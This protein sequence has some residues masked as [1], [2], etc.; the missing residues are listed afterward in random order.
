MLDDRSFPQFYQRLSLLGAIFLVMLLFLLNRLW[1][2]QVRQTDDFT[3]TIARQCVR[4]IRLEPVRGRLFA[5]DGSVL[6][7]NRARYDLVFHPADM[8]QPGGYANTVRFILA[9]AEQLATLLNRPMPLTA[10][11]LE[12]H[13]RL[14]PA[15]DLL[16]FEDLTTTDIAIIEET[17][18]S[19][20]G[21]EIVPTIVRTYPQPGVA[22][23]LLGFSGRRIPE[24]AATAAPRIHYARPELHG[25]DGL[26]KFYEQELAGRGGEKLVRVNTAGYIHDDI[27]VTEPP[28]DGNDL[29]LTLDPKAQRAAQAALAG[30]TGAIVM[31]DVRTGA[32]LAMASSPSYDLATLTPERYRALAADTI[33]RPLINRAV[34][35][36]YLPGSI[37]KPLTAL[38]ALHQK[39]IR[40][41]DIV[42][43]TGGYTLGNKLIRCWRTGG[44]GPVNLIGAIAGSC[45]T[46]FITAGLATGG[47]A[48]V[49]FLKAAGFGE[50][51][52]IDLPSVA[53]GF[54]ASRD[55]VR[56]KWKRAWLPV[57]T[58]YISI[59]QG[60]VSE[61]PLQA[62]MT[63][64]AI[65]NG[66]T[67]FRP[68]LVASVRDPAG[69]IRAITP[70]IA[71]RHLPVTTKNLDLVRRGM[72]QAVNGDGGTAKTAKTPYLTL[73]GKTG[74]AEV[75][76]VAGRHKNTWFIGFGPWEKPQYAIAVLIEHGDSGGHTAA[77]VAGRFITAWL[78][79]DHVAETA[80]SPPEPPPAGAEVE[81]TAS[82]EAP[83]PGEPPPA[84]E[85]PPPDTAAPTTDTD[86][87]PL[88]PPGAFLED[89]D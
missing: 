61:S 16:L 40:P 11:R 57:D 22:S 68:F 44:H 25:R 39:A 5:R 51:P 81:P 54:L 27:G 76:A 53:S 6:V 14:Y 15:L 72:W 30:F 71:R 60:P 89:Q 79:P 24:L 87:T 41:E 38:Y 86:A 70:P 78:A 84:G 47:D 62:A 9:E 32:V 45:N 63:T 65:A 20:P 13:L 18:P 28:V 58:A 66:G 77:P 59:G 75:D 8:R 52:E 64:A 55:W 46:Y 23:Q 37:I 82:G 1:D 2:L 10:D 12:R 85:P 88:G 48:Q 43:C 69:Q 21:V 50:S 4:H 29:L 7:D 36:T 31:L 83:A 34:S 56:A 80:E 35:S 33:H 26:V 3:D 67:L 42:D 74:T 49:A 17:M 19:P 73:A